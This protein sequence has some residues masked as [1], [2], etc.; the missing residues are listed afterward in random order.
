MEIKIPFFHYYSTFNLLK[1]FNRFRKSKSPKIHTIICYQQS[2]FYQFQK[3]IYVQ[4]CEVQQIVI[5]VYFKGW[6]V[7]AIGDR[8]ETFY[9][10][11]SR[12]VLA[13]GYRS[14]K[15]LIHQQDVLQ[16]QAKLWAVYRFSFQ[17]VKLTDIKK[18]YIGYNLF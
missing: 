14:G 1:Y 5:F 7:T 8:Y 4:S 10:H 17:C 6:H 11:I 2:D 12:V 3:V 16:L 9:F 15:F 18:M 13:T